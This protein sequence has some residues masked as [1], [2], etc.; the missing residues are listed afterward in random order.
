[1]KTRPSFYSLAMLAWLVIIL[2]IQT[3]ASQPLNAN[4][5]D[6]DSDEVEQWPIKEKRPFCNAFAGNLI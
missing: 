5:I 2:Y 1:M 3:S 6:S 4:Q